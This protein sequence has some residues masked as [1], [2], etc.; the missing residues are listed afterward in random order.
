MGDL[1]YLNKQ[2]PFEDDAKAAKGQPNAELVEILGADEVDELLSYFQK[3]ARA[4]K[5]LQLF[6]EEVIEKVS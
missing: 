6:F 1:V 4:Q 5:G 2:G 3:E